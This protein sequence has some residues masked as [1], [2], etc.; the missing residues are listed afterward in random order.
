MSKLFK[1]FFVTALAIFSI[2]G[3]IYFGISELRLRKDLDNR[4]VVTN[5]VIYE[6]KSGNRTTMSFYYEFD[7]DGQRY[8]GYFGG[9]GSWLINVGDTIKLRYDPLDPSRNKRIKTLVPTKKTTTGDII[10]CVIVVIAV[11][12]YYFFKIRRALRE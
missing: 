7:V 11:G 12:I 3:T 10:F 8:T 2:G 4:G 5:G 1:I 6:I 9:Y